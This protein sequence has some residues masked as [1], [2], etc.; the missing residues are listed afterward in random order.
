M[1]GL[2]AGTSRSSVWDSPT[3]RNTGLMN[4]FRAMFKI[5]TNRLGLALANPKGCWL[6]AVR[7]APV[8]TG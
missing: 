3:G 8:H 2:E 4:S 6:Q 1:K 7:A 5:F